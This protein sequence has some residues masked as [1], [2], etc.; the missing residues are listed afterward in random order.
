MQVPFAAVN[1]ILSIMG[2]IQWGRS[3]GHTETWDPMSGKRRFREITSSINQSLAGLGFDTAV[4]GDRPTSLPR[5]STLCLPAQCW[6]P[7]VVAMVWHH[8]WSIAGMIKST[9]KQLLR[10]WH[11][12]GPCCSDGCSSRCGLEPLLQSPLPQPVNAVNLKIASTT[13][14]WPFL[15]ITGGGGLEWIWH[16]KAI[17]G[18]G[19]ARM[20]A[21]MDII[22]LMKSEPP[23]MS[24]WHFQATSITF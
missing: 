14:D 10:M 11:D 24:S 9:Y 1:L 2:A 20:V 8:G 5:P 13:L 19:W 21:R 15:P 3:L 6:R 4:L 23:S 7:S 22:F 12:K 16:N 18:V 17:Q